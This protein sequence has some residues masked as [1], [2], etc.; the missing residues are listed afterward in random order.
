M[1]FFWEMLINHLFWEIRVSKRVPK[2]E[3]CCTCLL[4]HSMLL[5]PCTTQN[6]QNRLPPRF[7]YPGVLT[8]CPPRSP[9]GFGI[10]VPAP[11]GSQGLRAGGERLLES[12]LHLGHQRQPLAVCA[13]LSKKLGQKLMRQVLGFWNPTASGKA[14]YSHSVLGAVYIDES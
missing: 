13:A 12:T 3:R 8:H 14:G 9:P 7:T 5:L 10:L 11:W 2:K 4:M 6:E 1:H